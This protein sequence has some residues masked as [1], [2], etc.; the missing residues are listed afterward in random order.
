MARQAISDES[1]REAFAEYKCLNCSG[2]LHD[3]ET[4]EYMGQ[5]YTDCCHAEVIDRFDKT[6]GE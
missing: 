1:I 2:H 4:Y 5:K 6:E 3:D